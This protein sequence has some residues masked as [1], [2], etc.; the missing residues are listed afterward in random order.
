MCNMQEFYMI[1]TVGI[2]KE[3]FYAE[4][5]EEIICIKLIKKP[6]AIKLPVLY[7]KNFTW[8]VRILI[9]YPVHPLHRC[10]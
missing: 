2:E 10:K 6:E 5:A 1:H 8:L 3:G 9:L 4:I 7:Y